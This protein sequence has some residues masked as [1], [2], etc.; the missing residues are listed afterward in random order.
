MWKREEREED[1]RGA[2]EPDR[3]EVSRIRGEEWE[4][5]S[6]TQ[7]THDL[8]SNMGKKEENGERN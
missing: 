4:E 1:L 8:K 5:T 6:G 2:D 7:I 3:K